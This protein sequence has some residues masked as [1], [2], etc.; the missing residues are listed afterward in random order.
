MS[1]EFSTSVHPL[2][3]Y[4][5]TTGGSSLPGKDDNKPSGNTM[6]LKELIDKFFADLVQRFKDLFKIFDK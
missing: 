1:R 3:T 2:T 5:N 4:K 6:T